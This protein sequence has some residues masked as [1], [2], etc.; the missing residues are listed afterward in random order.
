MISVPRVQM[1]S[2]YEDER[3]A[4]S[5]LSEDIVIEYRPQILEPGK[6]TNITRCG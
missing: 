3:P 5:Q 1:P 6:R 2:G 4:A